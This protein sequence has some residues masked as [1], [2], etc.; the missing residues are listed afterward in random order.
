MRW[1]TYLWFLI[2]M[3]ICAAVYTLYSIHNVEAPYASV[4]SPV[5]R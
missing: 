4:D 2:W 1:S 3:V 5:Q